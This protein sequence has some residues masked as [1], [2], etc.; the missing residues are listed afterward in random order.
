MKNAPIFTSGFYKELISDVIWDKEKQVAFYL[1]T[2]FH[3]NDVLQSFLF[4]G[5]SVDINNYRDY[6]LNNCSYI[7]YMVDMYGFGA[8]A[9]LNVSRD[10]WHT[11]FEC[12]H[13][14]FLKDLFEKHVSHIETV[15]NDLLKLIYCVDYNINFKIS[16]EWEEYKIGDYKVSDFLNSDGFYVFDINNYRFE[17]IEENFNEHI[18]LKLIND[19]DRGLFYALN[20]F[21]E[22]QGY[23]IYNLMLSEDT[24]HYLRYVGVNFYSK[25]IEPNEKF[26]DLTWEK[27]NDSSS[28]HDENI[29]E[30]F[31]SDLERETTIFVSDHSS[32]KY[33]SKS[34]DRLDLLNQFESLLF[35]HQEYWDDLSILS[36]YQI[37]NKEIEILDLEELS[38]YVANKKND[39][40][41]IKKYKRLYE[42]LIIEM[43]KYKKTPQ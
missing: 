24:Q 6:S 3:S 32:I 25:T 8:K 43:D 33:L 13:A 23:N 29:F 4:K 36:P 15:E 22:N 20:N 41:N 9:I 11:D 21:C 27:L 37:L 26:N 1:R 7:D 35:K 18:S 17:G 12:K 34:D 40:P 30:N 16:G 5:Q 31:W 10:Y 38:I 28:N 14:E 19:N 2:N 39:L 42:K